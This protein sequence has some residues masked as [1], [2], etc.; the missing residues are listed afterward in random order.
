M[1]KIKKLIYL[2]ILILVLA[3]TLSFFHND[4]SNNRKV[5]IV[6]TPELVKSVL[7]VIKEKNLLDEYLPNNVR[8][9]WVNIDGTSNIRDA[10][11]TGQADIG[12]L[13]T[14]GYIN[15]IE[16]KYPLY[17]I[18]NSDNVALYLVS[19]NDSIKKIEELSKAKKIAVNSLGSSAHVALQIFAKENF[20]DYNYFDDIL[21]SPSQDVITNSIL[22]SKDIDVAVVNINQ[23][24]ILKDRVRLIQRIDKAELPLSNYLV[25]NIDFANNN[26]D[27]IEAFYNAEKKSIKYLNDNS[28]EASKFLAPLY[29]LSSEQVLSELENNKRQILVVNYDKISQTLFDLKL[30]KEKPKLFIDLPKYN[31]LQK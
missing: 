2:I 14:I 5:T 20:G 18:S 10:L 11:S 7:N 22:T 4:R 3:I 19:N 8:I 6:T 29:N 12:P 23:Y 9:E 13:G 28:D 27:I 31:E 1:I 30:L 21:L 15:A 24:F 25:S 17:L 26:K 16:K